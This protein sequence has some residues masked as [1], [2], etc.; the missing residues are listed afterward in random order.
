MASILNPLTFPLNQHAL[1]E[2]SAGTG[3]T[4]T[5]AALYVRAIVEKKLS[6]NQILVLTFTKAATEELKNRIRERLIEAASAFENTDFGDDFLQNLKAQY[7]KDSHKNHAQT[8]R[9][10]AQ[11]MDE[12]RI[13]TIHA[14]CFSVLKSAALS[15]RAPFSLKIVND[16]EGAQIRCAA[17]CN[18]WREFVTP[19]SES[20]TEKLLTFFKSPKELLEKIKFLINENQIDLNFDIPTSAES[21]KNYENVYLNVQKEIAEKQGF[22]N[23]LIDFLILSKEKKKFNGKKLQTTML[24]KIINELKSGET[25]S[26][27]WKS[28]GKYLTLDFLKDIWKENEPR[29][30][31]FII[32]EDWKN[33]L[34]NAELELQKNLFYFAAKNIRQKIKVA[35]QKLSSCDF[36]S[37]LLECNAALEKNPKMVEWLRAQFPFALIDEFQDTDSIQC[38][39]FK[40]IYDYENKNNTAKIILIGDPK[41]AIYAFRGADVYTYLKVRQC[42]KDSIY[43][44]NTNYR[45]T[46]EVIAVSNV[47]FENAEKNLENGAFG[48]KNGL[49][50]SAVSAQGKKE[51]LFLN[52]KP[53]P[54]FQIFHLKKEEKEKENK[55]IWLEKL[56]LKCAFKIAELFDSKNKV[57]FNT[58]RKFS[59]ADCAVLVNTSKEALIIKKAL[60]KFGIPSAYL[61]EQQSVYT[62]NTAKELFIIL[63]AILN[64]NEWK[65]KGALLTNILKTDYETIYNFKNNENAIEK[66]L[67]QFKG[68]AQH[69]EK[70]GIAATIHQILFDFKTPQKLQAHP[71]GTRIL[72]DTRHLAELLEEESAYLN[73]AHALLDFLS[74][75]INPG[76]SVVISQSAQ[77]HLIRLESDE[78]I[79]KII[80]IHKSKG[81]EYPLVFLPFVSN[82]KDQF[83]LPSFYH[84]ENNAI[85]IAWEENKKEN[86]KQEYLLE[87]IRKLYV[88]LTRAC[89]ALWVGLYEYKENNALFHLLDN[90]IQ[91]WAEN[92][93]AVLDE[94]QTPIQPQKTIEIVEENNII[95]TTHTIQHYKND[96]YTISSFSALT[97]N[98]PFHVIDN[99]EKNAKKEFSIEKS[100]PSGAAFGTFVHDLIEKSAKKGFQ[101]KEE[102]TFENLNADDF[103]KWFNIIIKNPL[104]IDNQPSLQ[105]LNPQKILTEMEF[106]FP[107]EKKADNIQNLNNLIID[108]IIPKQPRPLLNQNDLNGMLKGFIDLTFENNGRYYVMD[109][110]TNRLGDYIEDYNTNNIQ[111][112]ILNHRYDL[113]MTLYLLALHRFL[114][115]RLKDYNPQKHMGGAIYYFLRGAENIETGGFYHFEPSV[116]FL[117]TLHQIF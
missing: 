87:E 104:R 86:I 90:N 63:D 116:D 39:I 21:L 95:K 24:D 102:L 92:G 7:P 40:K 58:E 53:Y 8:L 23:N 22:L 38:A 10:A 60:Q 96:Y 45:A 81:L 30:N 55:D 25:P 5:I 56:A 88:A 82:V 94:D 109:Y 47:L 100:F 15:A 64:P 74:L 78:N 112:T 57:Y 69:W 44:L 19:L 113:Q 80:T 36:N 107:V 48:F 108:N 35:Q 29:L 16:E 3:K 20:A 83:H 72:T 115:L 9:L 75:K 85:Q 67:E 62:Q 76:E 114:K 42:L 103:K 32:F 2:A 79:V 111:T 17:A 73:S 65:I 49:P 117:K 98:L 61:S 52:D 68:Y 34:E 59:L 71:D 13:H 28:F 106:I 50:F 110:K 27:E 89:Y 41:Q 84:D 105:Q 46:K 66:L 12:A 31:D 6:P 51:Q 91:K 93:N 14:W 70:F 77:D 54:A 11:M 26:L 97:Y 101:L 43:T 4:W 33:K 37:L 18:F 99:I 1:I